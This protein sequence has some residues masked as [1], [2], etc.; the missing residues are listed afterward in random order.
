M[1]AVRRCLIE[2]RVALFEEA[3][4]RDLADDGDVLVRRMKHGGKTVVKGKHIEDVWPQIK[5]FESYWGTGSSL[6]KSFSR[7]KMRCRSKKKRRRDE[8][9]GWLQVDAY[10]GN[11]SCGRWY[12]SMVCQRGS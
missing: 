3:V 8:C 6:G 2:L 5:K 7:V 10:A 11:E 9:A 4:C 12:R 1:L